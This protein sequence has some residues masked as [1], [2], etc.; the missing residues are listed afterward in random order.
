M[1]RHSLLLVA[2]ERLAW[3]AEELPPLQPDEVL[4]QTTSGAIS[5][6]AEL[7][8]FRCKAR[9]SDPAHYPRMTGYES[10]GTIIACGSAIKHL[11]IGERV[12]A[13]YGH[14]THGIVPEQK[15]I[16][17]PD[18]LSDAI[19]LLAI[20]TCDVT[21]GIRKVAPAPDEA[22]LVTG[23]GAIGLLTIFM[24][25]TLGV[26]DIDVVEPQEK[27]RAVALHF[28]ARSAW[29]PDDVAIRSTSYAVGIECSSNNDAF[30]LLQS[31]MQH[32]GRI[33]ILSDGN[34]EPLVLSPDFHSKEL[35]IVGSSDGWDY[36]E[37]AKLFFP[38]VRAKVCKLEQIFEYETLAANLADTFS[39][40]AVGTISPIKV[41]VH[42]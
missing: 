1:H 3:V 42:Y 8:Q 17:V 15:V 7:P 22:V 29:H 32:Y 30:A 33:C 18:D 4:V 21:K 9:H 31:R 37:H 6:G 36:Q 39:A 14:S 40:L 16:S 2:P 11:R 28:G 20:L 13:F 41:L 38:I 10:V 26:Q 19:A 23:A 12:V 5:I 24:L 25:T 27:R 34:L 35:S